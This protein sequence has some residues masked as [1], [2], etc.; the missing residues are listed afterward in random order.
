MSVLN[1]LLFRLRQ[2]SRRFRDIL[3]RRYFFTAEEYG[4]LFFQCT[5]ERTFEIIV[6][7]S[8][9]GVKSF[10][11]G[12][13]SSVFCKIGVTGFTISRPLPPPPDPPRLRVLSLNLWNYNHFVSFIF[14]TIHSSSIEADRIPLIL[15]VIH[16]YQPDIIGLQE[17]PSKTFDYVKNAPAISHASFICFIMFL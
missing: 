4:D 1:L 12:N 6:S 16:K 3:H 5:A 8:Y 17:V 2:V 9:D 10:P 14:N 13:H 7:Q 11:K 15:E